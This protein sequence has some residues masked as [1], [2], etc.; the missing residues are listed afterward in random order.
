M[1]GIGQACTEAAA[2][3]DDAS[4]QTKDSSDKLCSNAMAADESIVYSSG[5]S[6]ASRRVLYPVMQHNVMSIATNQLLLQLYH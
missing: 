2:S 1:N 4:Y 5:S 6:V 3:D